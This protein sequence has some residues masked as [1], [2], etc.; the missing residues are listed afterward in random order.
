MSLWYTGLLMSANTFVST[1]LRFIIKML[2]IKIICILNV[3]IHFHLVD[4]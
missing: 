1:T 4:T 3:F 2:I